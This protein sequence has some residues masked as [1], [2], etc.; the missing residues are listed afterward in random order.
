MYKTRAI[1]PYR[2]VSLY[3]PSNLFLSFLQEPGQLINR[4]SNWNLDLFTWYWDVSSNCI[5]VGVIA[6]PE[7]RDRTT[8]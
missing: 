5:N 4:F 1:F 6:A 8:G 2:L 3:E 7:G